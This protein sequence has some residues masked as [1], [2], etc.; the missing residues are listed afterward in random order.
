MKHEVKFDPDSVAKVIF[1]LKKDD[2][3]VQVIELYD[4]EDGMIG[5]VGSE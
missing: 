5:K 4:C 1:K 2:F 3:S